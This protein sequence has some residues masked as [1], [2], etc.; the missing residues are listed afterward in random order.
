MVV[1]RLFDPALV[2]ER[3]PQKIV[4]QQLAFETLG[5][6]GVLQGFLV[7]QYGLRVV[8]LLHA[9]VPHRHQGLSFDV[10]EVTIRREQFLNRW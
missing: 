6:P 5:L 3:A 7:D 2:V 10:V 4:D 9:D 8:C 1:L